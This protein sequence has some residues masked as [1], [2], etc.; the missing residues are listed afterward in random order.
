MKIL[1]SAGP[2]R[3]YLD[4][5]RFISNPSTGKMGYLIAEKSL[6]KGHTVILVSGP[7]HLRHPAKVKFIS[8]ETA[9]EMKI[10]ILKNFKS[11][12]ALIMCAAVSDWRPARKSPG[13]IKQKKTWKLNLVPN[14]DILKEV[15]KIK[16]HNQ[17]VIGFA[18]ETS[19]IV[20]NAV[21]KM[22]EKNLDLIVA[23]TP[24]FF[25]DGAKKS[26][27]YFIYR[28]GSTEEFKEM[29]KSRLA[30]K[31][32]TLLEKIQFNENKTFS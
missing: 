10:S 31:I 28:D 30:Q 26:K 7:T 16:M 29:T 13:K 11:V 17:I 14:P 3:E 8:T 6:K 32:V 20:K 5:V 22:K 9:E 23:D 1:I 18:L 27:V 2:T 21:G 19:D 25:G 24:E 15:S 4:P 12:D